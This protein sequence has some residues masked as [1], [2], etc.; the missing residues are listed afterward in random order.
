MAISPQ[1]L[2]RK[3]PVI[4]FR[5]SM[6]HSWHCFSSPNAVPMTERGLIFPIVIC[7][8]ITERKTFYLGENFYHLIEIDCMPLIPNLSR[9][10]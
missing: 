1:T 6:I 9:S 2:K 4:T 3:I 8:Q 5:S 7:L 10:T